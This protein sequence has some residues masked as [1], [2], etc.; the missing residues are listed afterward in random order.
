MRIECDIRSV[1]PVAE[2][3][4]QN[5]AV[6]ET[7]AP[8][9]EAT[10][11]IRPDSEQMEE[12]RR[13]LSNVR[14]M[15]GTQVLTSD[16]NGTIAGTGSTESAHN[17]AIGLPYYAGGPVKLDYKRS[18]RHFHEAVHNGNTEPQFYIG[19]IY[20]EGYGTRQCRILGLKRARVDW[21]KGLKFFKHGTDYGDEDVL[22]GDMA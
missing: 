2:G 19:K 8:L 18:L 11:R 3:K 4:F 22:Y 13:L 20:W 10:A 9:L 15:R 21:K 16:M 12:H 6:P 1:I 17:F 7:M 5:A 14:Q